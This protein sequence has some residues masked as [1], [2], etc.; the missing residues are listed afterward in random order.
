[1]ATRWLVETSQDREKGGLA[2]AVLAEESEDLVLV[3]LKV[4]TVES[5]VAIGVSLKEILNHEHFL[6]FLD[7]EV[8]VNGFNVVTIHVAGLP[9]TFLHSL[10]ILAS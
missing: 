3:D 2:G 8:D 9:F 6:V 5:F 4:N 1:M 7:S 10:L